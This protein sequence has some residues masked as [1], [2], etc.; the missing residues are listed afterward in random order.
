M[1]DSDYDE[2][3]EKECKTDYQRRKKR[4]EERQRVLR[5]VHYDVDKILKEKAEQRQREV[6]GNNDEMMNDDNQ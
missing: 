4:E 3:D 6:H 5:W 1:N 2:Q